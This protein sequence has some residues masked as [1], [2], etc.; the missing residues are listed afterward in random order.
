[1][2]NTVRGAAH[3]PQNF[4]LGAF[5]KPHRGHRRLSGAAHSLQN[6]SPSGFSAPQFEQRTVSSWLDGTIAGGQIRRVCGSI[7]KAMPNGP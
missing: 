3:C 1:M 7:L 5:S 2:A 4:A 6:F